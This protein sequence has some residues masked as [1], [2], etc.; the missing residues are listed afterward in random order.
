MSRATRRGPGGPGAPAARQAAP[1]RIS[2]PTRTHTA[3]NA[4]R[5]S[6][7]VRRRVGTA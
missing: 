1:A 4:G 6:L 7:A 2:A 3:M 5:G